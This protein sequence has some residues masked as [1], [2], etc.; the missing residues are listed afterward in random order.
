MAIV[1]VV[2][3]GALILT[4]DAD[5]LRS[6]TVRDERSEDRP[7]AT[8]AGDKAAAAR[9][10]PDGRCRLTPAGVNLSFTRCPASQSNRKTQYTPR[11]PALVVAVNPNNPVIETE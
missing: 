1:A 6:V 9:I 7:R 2:C 10:P 5:F 11:G 4:H 3:A 8:P